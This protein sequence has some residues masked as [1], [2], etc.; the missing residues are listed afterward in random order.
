[1]NFL[2]RGT[3]GTFD[4]CIETPE[5]RNVLLSRVLPTR[6]LSDTSPI[7]DKVLT[8]H[9]DASTYFECRVLGHPFYNPD[10]SPPDCHLSG[11]LEKILQGHNYAN[12]KTRDAAES[13]APVFAEE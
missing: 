8:P 10:L 3:T 1:V 13:R 4:S 7:H 6:E 9:T 12:D 5:S 2:A 11:P